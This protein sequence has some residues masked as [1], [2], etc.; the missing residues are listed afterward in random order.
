MKRLFSF[1]KSQKVTL[2]F[3]SLIILI[4]IILLN[5]PNNS[6]LSDPFDVDSSKVEFFI[7]QVR[8]DSIKKPS[9]K[10]NRYQLDDFN[11]N[12]YSVKDW[13]NIGFSKRQSESIVKYKNSSGGFESKE[14]LKSVYVI[15]EK[16]YNEIES[17]IRI[18]KLEPENKLIENVRDFVNLNE[19]S[20]SEL[21]LIKG[22]GEI[23]AK[24]IIK[25]KIKLGGFYHVD[26]LREVYGLSVEN[27]DLIKTQIFL[28]SSYVSKF[29]I[30]SIDFNELKKHPY[31]NWDLAEFILKER[32]TQKIVNKNRLMVFKDT[33]II[34]KVLPYISYK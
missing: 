13:M 3:L 2:I 7:E 17:F 30:N 20:E 32:S 26:Q 10:I 33:M 1:N 14:D 29:E 21:I 22:I 18:P 27:F 19:A 31:I 15:S 34:K 11:P 25:Y 5:R 4:L 12:N 23:L 28:E 9:K 6:I 16:K 8:L 24:R